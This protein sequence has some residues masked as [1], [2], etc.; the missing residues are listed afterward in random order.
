MAGQGKEGRTELTA[1]ALRQALSGLAHDAGRIALRHYRQIRGRIPD[2]AFEI[3]PNDTIVTAADQEVEAFLRGRLP[4]L[5]LPAAFVG[6]ETARDEDTVRAARDSEWVWVV[7]PIDGTAGFVD[8]LA[9]FGVSIGLLRDGQPYAGVLFFPALNHLYTA[10]QGAGAEYDGQRVHVLDE[11]PHPDRRVLYVSGEAH[12]E[13]RICYSG[14]TR[15]LAS[16]ALH[17]ALVARGVAVGALAT[18]HVWDFAAAAAILQEAGGLI[19][20]LNGEDID[21]RD[22][23]DGKELEP[24]VLGTPPRLWE[25]VVRSIAPLPA[26]SP[27]PPIPGSTG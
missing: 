6:E 2:E 3:K 22:A 19:K 25:Q 12:R 1:L 9:L 10:V 20:H 24:A 7:D 4:E 23:L 21:W 26:A 14:K 17:F 5:G 13:F 16:A 11:E 27:C 15:S 8:G 18:A